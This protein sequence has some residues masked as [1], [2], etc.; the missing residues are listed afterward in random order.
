M[1][2]KQ[3]NYST[4]SLAI[5][6]REYRF[7]KGFLV[8]LF[9]I[10][11]FSYA[12]PSIEDSDQ[13]LNK[14]LDLFI[15]GSKDQ[16]IQLLKSNEEALLKN[17]IDS[18]NADSYLLLGRI[19]FY[20]EMDV[21][22]ENVLNTALS[23]NKTL[24]KAHY[25][26]GLINM[27][28]NKLLMAETSFEKAIGLD[29]SNERFFI[30]LG[31]INERLEKLESA[32][33]NYK[34][35]LSLNQLNYTANF[36]LAN[37]YVGKND[38]D[39]AEKHYKLALKTK[40][41]NLL[42]NYNLGQLYQTNKSHELALKY[43]SKVIELD[44]TNWR[45][46]A[47][48]IQENQALGKISE[49]NHSIKY[50]YKLWSENKTNELVKQ[51]FFIRE[52]TSIKEGKLFALEYFKLAGDRA[53]KFIFKIQDPATG[54]NI[55]EISLGSYDGTTQISRETGGIGADERIYHLDGYLP[56]G[57]H[58]TY[59][60]FNKQPSYD[61]IKQMVLNVL[62]GKHKSISS[63]VPANA[64]KSPSQD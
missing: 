33:L 60:F 62:N 55:I 7:M 61:D 18:S 31:R 38:N 23:Y 2:F 20:A 37:L 52:Q 16:A 28:A 21:K 13:Q 44:S 11:S 8:L 57:S 15:S 59:A 42:L 41:D 54:H 27:Y 1:L 29:D 14:I 5:L 56:N 34:K 12:S 51:G 10:S 46:V 43:F 63:M 47:K 50:I 49:R 53:R 30:E 19:Y 32:M 25:F 36:N 40:P 17:L 24:P 3:Y 45:A 64:N 39:K 58:Y 4:A 9:F 26:I 6:L 22:A 48:V 35:A